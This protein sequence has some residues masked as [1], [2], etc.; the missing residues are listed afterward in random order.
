MTKG[1]SIGF[2]SAGALLGAGG[3]YLALSDG[4]GEKAR[5]TFEAELRA[6]RGNRSLAFAHTEERLQ[7]VARAEKSRRQLAF[8]LTESLAVATATAT[9]I[10]LAVDDKKQPGTYTLL[11]GS[12]ALMSGLGFYIL[13]VETPTERVLRLYHD[14]P[15]LKL[16]LGASALPTGGV[17]FGLSG[18]F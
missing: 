13:S 10:G 5:Q 9:T 17:S 4:P 6:Q 16:R 8:W 7:D 1:A 11:Y 3:L 2:A 14:D 12:A 18:T 15:G